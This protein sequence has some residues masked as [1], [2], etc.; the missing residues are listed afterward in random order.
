MKEREFRTIYDIAAEEVE[1]PSKEPSVGFLLL[2]A[3][4]IFLLVTLIVFSISNYDYI[5][6]QLDDLESTEYVFNEE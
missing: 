3:S 5:L 4:G 6:S 2:K 1:I